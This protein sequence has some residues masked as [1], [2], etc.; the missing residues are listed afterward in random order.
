MPASTHS[1]ANILP[2]RSEHLSAIVNNRNIPAERRRKFRYS[3]DLGVRFDCSDA[4]ACISGVGIVVNM[5]SGGVL[6]A[7][8]NQPPVGALVEMRIEW[9]SLLNGRIPLQLIAIGRILR[10][11]PALFAATFVRHEFRTMK[12]P[13]QP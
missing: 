12:R 5:S 13:G 3:L 4:G 7:S 8:S 2:F 9:P 6:V 10:R 1:F 11:G